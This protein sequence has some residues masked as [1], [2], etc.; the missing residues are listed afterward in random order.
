[1]DIKNLTLFS[2][3]G[4]DSKANQLI[5]SFLSF[6]VSVIIY[7]KIVTITIITIA[8]CEVLSEIEE[9][10]EDLVVCLSK[11]IKGRGRKRVSGSVDV[12]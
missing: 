1:V 5:L 7:K 11:E 12:Q 4:L 8:L 3:S 6:A 9:N 10:S 2:T